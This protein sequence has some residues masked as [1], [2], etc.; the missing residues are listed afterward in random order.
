MELRARIFE[1][2][3]RCERQDE[4]MSQ[5]ATVAGSQRK[6][7]GAVT[8]LEETLDSRASKHA[9][10]TE[11]ATA[12]RAEDAL[13]PM[14][15]DEWEHLAPDT[16]SKI[17]SIIQRELDAD[18]LATTLLHNIYLLQQIKSHP[19]P[20]AQEL[21]TVLYRI[22]NDIGHMI[23]TI[24]PSALTESST[25]VNPCNSTTRAQGRTV[26]N[27]QAA[28]DSELDT[29]FLAIARIFRWVLNSTNILDRTPAG[30]ALH[31]QVV[32]CFV[33]LFRTSLE[34]IC[35]LAAS[36]SK[37]DAT[38]DTQNAQKPRAARPK[39]TITSPKD[40]Q[41]TPKLCRLL[42]TMV[43]SLDSSI[44]IH[45]DILDG[46][47]FFLLTRVGQ[48]LFV[49]V[50]E[51]SP[52]TTPAA[53]S[54]QARNATTNTPSLGDH[55]ISQSQAP[56][57]ISLLTNLTPLIARPSPLLLAEKA[58][59]K[60]QHTLLNTI[61]G[62]Q[63]GEFVHAL[64]EPCYPPNALD[65]TVDADVDALALREADIGE[66]YKHEVWKCVGWDVLAGHIAWP[67]EGGKN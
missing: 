3:R 27:A 47:L 36:C 66:W 4:Q 65:K 35:N 60:L 55:S 34:R 6:R 57:L 16:H 53:N 8:E 51:D 26:K 46:F 15:M 29:K 58:K 20:P 30:K 7:K 59:L 21:A 48:L 28:V 12:A 56:H 67:A 37:E 50:F 44:P 45:Q 33:T 31:G 52:I 39:T 25:N 18:M 5:V 32:Y 22:S 19:N 1:L 64:A 10:T 2:E 62:A 43:A 14:S 40:D 61:F 49:F 9:R 11:S 42:T 54:F 23:S 17:P 24:T 38:K 13:L 63:T 41:T